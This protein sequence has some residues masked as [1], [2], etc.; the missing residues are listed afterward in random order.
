MDSKR[1]LNFRLDPSVPVLENQWESWGPFRVEGKDS[2]QSVSL[3][4]RETEDNQRYVRVVHQD[5]G[6]GYNSRS[7]EVDIQGTQSDTVPD[8]PLACNRIAA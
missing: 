8:P 4:R 1:L 5:R 7:A 2:S 3:D 6:L